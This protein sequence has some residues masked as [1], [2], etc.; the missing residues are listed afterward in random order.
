MTETS[1]KIP[2]ASH[3]YLLESLYR[4]LVSGKNFDRKAFIVWRDRKIKYSPLI[5]YVY[6]N[7]DVYVTRQFA[8]GI[9]ESA[10]SYGSAMKDSFLASLEELLTT[11]VTESVPKLVGYVSTATRAK[12]READEQAVDEG[13]RRWLREVIPDLVRRLRTNE[14]EEHLNAAK[15][16]PSTTELKTPNAAVVFSGYK[17]LPPNAGPVPTLA[18]IRENAPTAL[19]D[20]LVDPWMASLSPISFPRKGRP[21][22]SKNAPP[23]TLLPVPKIPDE[24]LQGDPPPTKYFGEKGPVSSDLADIITENIRLPPPET[25][26]RPRGRPLGSKNKQKHEQPKPLNYS[27]IISAPTPTDS[28]ALNL[29]SIAIG[30]SP[31]LNTSTLADAFAATYPK[32]FKAI[33]ILNDITMGKTAYDYLLPFDTP[34]QEQIDEQNQAW[35]AEAEQLATQYEKENKL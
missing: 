24:V 32:K 20:P 4:T 28:Q 29:F 15:Y 31:L 9:I 18:S 23:P 26:K 21:P 16:K 12:D 14:A 25:P 1:P 17:P 34:T 10:M 11:T 27:D 22:G 5:H 3:P 13:A 8:D 6:V 35:L 2:P 19:P 7:T 33:S 30:N